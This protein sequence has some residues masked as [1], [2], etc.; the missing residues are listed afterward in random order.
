MDNRKL[1]CK[2]VILKKIHHP[3]EILP[4]PS[5]NNN[6]LCMRWAC[7]LYFQLKPPK[8]C[9]LNLKLQH[10]NHTNLGFAIISRI[11]TNVSQHVV[12]APHYRPLATFWLTLL[13]YSPLLMM[14]CHFISKM[15]QNDGKWF[16]YSLSITTEKAPQ[17]PSHIHHKHKLVEKLIASLYLVY[18]FWM[19]IICKQEK[20]NNTH[21]SLLSR[22]NDRFHLVF[23]P[24]ESSFSRQTSLH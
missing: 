3:A 7:N 15:L 4:L 22:Y 12:N 16:C 6:M 10:I 18:H 13:R 2:R 14:Y 21:T 20:K 5:N 9:P 11:I 17:T 8:K 19:M 23:F 1:I 24:H